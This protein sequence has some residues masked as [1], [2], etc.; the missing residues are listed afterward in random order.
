[1]NVLKIC[2]YD[3]GGATI[4]AKRQAQ[5]LRA[6]GTP[7]TFLYLHD[8]RANGEMALQRGEN[9]IRLSVPTSAWSYSGLIATAYWRDNRSPESNTWISLFHAECLWD[10]MLLDVCREFDVIHFHWIA[11]SVSARLLDGLRGLGKR[12]VFTGHDMN[13]FTGGCHYSGGCRKYV[14]ACRDCPQLLTDFMGLI[15][16][17]LR[18]KVAVSSAL[19]ATWLFPSH[20]LADEFRLSQLQDKPEATQVLHN[21]LDARRFAPAGEARRRELRRELGFQ[22]REMVCVAGAAD[23][24][25]LRKGFDYL[26]AAVDHLCD[27]LRGPDNRRRCAVVTIGRG[28]PSLSRRSPHLRHVHLGPVSEDRVI[29]LFQAADLLLFPSVEENFSNTILESLLCGCPVLGFAIGGVPDI[30]RPGVNGWLVDTVSRE[31]FAAA[32]EAAA[33][34]ELLADMRAA[35][36]AWRAG[37][38]ADYD[39]P[40]F[41]D[42]LGRIYDDPEAVT[43]GIP[44][45]AA[46]PDPA[47]RLHKLIFAEAKAHN[48]H[49]NMTL[50]QGIIRHKF[51]AIAAL[52]GLTEPEARPAPSLPAIFTGFSQPEPHPSYGRVAW[53]CQQANVLFRCQP[54]QRPALGLQVPNESWVTACLETATERLSAACNDRPATVL[55]VGGGPRDRYAYLWVLPDPDSLAPDAYNVLTLRFSEPYVDAS[56]DRRLIC[57]LHCQALL[58][59]LARTLPDPDAVPDLAHSTRCALRAD[60]ARQRTAGWEPAQQAKAMTTVAVRAWL[61]LLEHESWAGEARA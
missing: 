4:A 49:A 8:D 24:G 13:H 1:M 42:R 33:R 28:R 60:Q 36:E 7:C 29:A 18:L 34:P 47:D 52:Q 20:W 32:V 51:Q 5:A 45:P 3:D 30:V 38:A 26:E 57:L 11:Q 21:C 12:V 17:S 22:E 16:S 40:G 19:R 6:Q 15:D 37:H 41:A 56:K 43:S 58:C 59:D 9:E 27:T 54:G 25:E 53:V 50:A 23:N 44:A 39:Y 46:P 31:H 2:T 61:D 10:R 48:G 55:R 14:T 35:T